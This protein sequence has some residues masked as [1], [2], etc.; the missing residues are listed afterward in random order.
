MTVVLIE[1]GALEDIEQGRQWYSSTESAL[2]FRFEDAVS[3][4]I[5]LVREFPEAYAIQYREARRVRLRTFPYNLYYWCDS[6][7]G[8]AA[9]VACLHARRASGSWKSRF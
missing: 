3:D 9:V 4:A 8:V 5:D 1:K 7:R 6:E 2:G